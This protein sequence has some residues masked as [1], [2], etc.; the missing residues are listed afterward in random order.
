MFK[1]KKK[2][3]NTNQKTYYDSSGTST[4]LLVRSTATIAPRMLALLT[5]NYFCFEI[6]S[7]R[8]V[9]L[10]FGILRASKTESRKGVKIMCESGVVGV[11]GPPWFHPV[12]LILWCF[13]SYVVFVFS[14]FLLSVIF[15]FVVMLSVQPLFFSYSSFH[16]F[17]FR[18]RRV[19]PLVVLRGP[20]LWR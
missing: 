16:P 5:L 12:V 13:F 9:G 8:T 14:V 15:L 19:H 10:I 1:E 18:P 17:C 2:C 20:T 6:L 11:V 4:H 3:S 7:L